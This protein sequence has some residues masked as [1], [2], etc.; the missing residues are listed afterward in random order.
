MQK[1]VGYLRIVCLCSFFLLLV[2]SHW[3]HAQQG[4]WAWMGGP[5][6]INDVGNY[7]TMG[8]PAPTNMPPAMHMPTT[9]TDDSG[10][11]W[12]FGGLSGVFAGYSAMWRYEPTQNVWTWMKGSSNYHEP[13]VYGVMGV[14]DPNNIPG[15]RSWG[16]PHWVDNNGDLWLFGGFG[17]GA[18]GGNGTLNDL[19]KFNVASNEWTWVKGPQNVNVPGSYG[20]LGVSSPTNLPPGRSGTNVTWVDDNNN[21]W[22]FGGLKGQSCLNDVWRYNPVTNEWTWMA[23]SSTLNVLPV[24]GIQ[25]QAAPTNNPGSRGGCYGAW[26]DC[27]GKFWMFGGSTLPTGNTYNDLWKFDPATL[28]WTWMNGSNLPFSTGNYS[29]LCTPGSGMIPSGRFDNSAVWTDVYGRFWNFG[30]SVGIGWDTWSDLW[31]YDPATDEFTWVKG[32]ASN[33][34]LGVFGTLG[35]PAFGNAPG[36]C[37]GSGSFQD[38]QGNLWLMGGMD[39]NFDARNDLWKFSVDSLCPAPISSVVI[40]TAAFTAQPLTGCAPLTVN[41]TNTST[42]ATHYLWVFGDGDSA[43]VASPSHTFNTI[44]TYQVMLIASSVGC[45]GNGRDTTFHTITVN[46]GF[47]LNLGAD[48][49]ICPGDSLVLNAGNPG[50]TFLWSDGSSGQTLTVDQAGSFWVEVTNLAGCIVRDTIV[51]SIFSNPLD[52]GPDRIICDGGSTLLDAANPGAAYLWSDNSTSQTLAVTVA[53]SYWVALTLPNGCRF[54]DT[55][56]V[57]LLP[58]PVV[59]LGQDQTVCSGDTFIFEAGT[60]PNEVLLWS[61][62]LQTQTIAASSP[63]LFWLQVTNQQGCSTRDTVLLLQSPSPVNNLGSDTMICD[64]NSMLLDAGNPGSNFIWSTGDNSQTIVVNQAGTYAVSVVSVDGCAAEEEIGIGLVY[65][66]ALE[67]GRDSTFCKLDRWVLDA[68]PGAA[69]FEWST[70]S[71]AQTL[72]VQQSGTYWVT[73]WNDCFTHSDSIHFVF[74][75][76]SVGP[77]IPTAFTPNGDGLN[78]VFKVEGLRITAQ[79]E[80]KIFDPWGALLFETRDMQGSWDGRFRGAPVQEGVY[81]LLVSVTDCEGNQR[82]VGKSITLIK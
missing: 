82:L 59:D 63:G 71:N 30:G 70:G 43:A 56:V 50:S 78:D 40:V 1:L 35:V 69:S 58:R 37:A 7:G 41:F 64:G 33:N 48:R 20:S 11:F 54:V 46:A 57:G 45:T 5:Q 47:P 38:L 65:D 80:M 74:L 34:Q 52:L 62:G 4:M 23:G 25:G 27:A 15:S 17:F 14:G 8:I 22:L 28:E 26:K 19:W 49:S 18:F 66:F 21:L 10:N 61:N 29:A 13:G 55:V 60:H 36:A 12:L 42:N 53:G 72:T 67:L 77:F 51:V 32:P 75:I 73:A 76:D 3:G 39:F 2:L 68:G 44:G 81:V 79:F 31:C 6:T 9:W 16:V 24:Y